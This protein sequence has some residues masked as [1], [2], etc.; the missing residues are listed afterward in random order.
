MGTQVV[1]RKQRD[2]DASALATVQPD[3]RT[4]ASR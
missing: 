2:N 4:D 3:E 1:E